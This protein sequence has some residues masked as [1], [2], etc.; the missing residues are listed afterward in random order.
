M[1]AANDEDTTSS[2]YHKIPLADLEQLL[3]T[4][5]QNG[6]STEEAARRLESGGPNVLTPPKKTPEWIKFSKT[7]FSGFAALLWMASILCF[8]AYAVARASSDEFSSDNL[9][10]G[11]ALVFVVIVSGLLTYFQ[12][13][14]SGKIME[15]FS[16]M[17]PPKATVRRDGSLMELEAADIVVGDIVEVKGGDK[18][19]ADIRILEA[20]SLKVSYRVFIKYCV[21]SLKCFLNSASS[22]AAL[23]F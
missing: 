6:L 16:K 4:D 20:S 23:V 18:V 2:D 14:R 22:A 10:V 12:E 3:G 19:P 15:S 1:S 7:M 8:I 13:R 5:F 21:L 11:C 17:V 9:Y